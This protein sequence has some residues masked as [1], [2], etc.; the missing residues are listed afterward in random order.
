MD[1]KLK[2]KRRV[3]WK[4]TIATFKSWKNTTTTSNI[5][6]MLLSYV[7]QYFGPTYR[8]RIPLFFLYGLH[9]IVCI[10]VRRVDCPKVPPWWTE[11]QGGTSRDPC[12]ADHSMP[13]L[14]A[15]HCRAGA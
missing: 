1:M 3:N 8:V 13:L 6:D 10:A 2:P 12:R 9:H 4:H 5:G 15:G 14:A 11:V 7:F